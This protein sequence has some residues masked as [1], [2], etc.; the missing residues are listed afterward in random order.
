[1]EY[2]ELLDYYNSIAGFGQEQEQARVL[3]LLH[4]KEQELKLK[5]EELARANNPNLDDI[6]GPGPKGKTLSEDDRRIADWL[7]HVEYVNRNGT[8]IGV[9]IKD[10]LVHL[11]RELL[12]GKKMNRAILF[13]HRHRIKCQEPGYEGYK[14]PRS[15]PRKQTLVDEPEIGGYCE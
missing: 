15:R 14:L 6:I 5:A 7:C 2:A 12:P 9:S 8:T 13:N 1:M 10:I 11:K 4:E 3:K